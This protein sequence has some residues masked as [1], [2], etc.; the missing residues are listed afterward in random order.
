MMP[1]PAAPIELK[2]ERL[3]ER[4]QRPLGGVGFRGLERD[5]VHLARGRSVAF[6]GA[7]AL[8][9]DG[10]TIRMHGDPHPGDIDREECAAVFAGKHAF[11][12]DGLPVPAV[13]A[14]DPV[15]LRDGV[16]AFEIGQLP[17]MGLTGADMAAIR[18]RRSACT[19]FAEKPITVSSRSEP[20]P[21]LERVAPATSAPPLRS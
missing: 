5:I 3:S 11:G 20:V 7:M 16:P 21:G 14:E 9:N 1:R 18:L 19:C 4:G 12:L 2:T 6:T 15:G 8:A 13:K 10:C 17:A